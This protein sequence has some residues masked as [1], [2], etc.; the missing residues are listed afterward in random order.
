MLL[1]QMKEELVRPTVLIDLRR[2]PDSAA[3]VDTAFGGVRIGASALLADLA[4]HPVSAMVS[5]PAEAS[6]TVGTPALRNMGNARRQSL[7]AAAVLVLSS[8][9]P[10]HK[11]GGDSCP[12]AAG[13]NQ[14]H[15]IFGGGPCFIVH[16]SDP[17]VALTALDARCRGAWSLRY[18]HRS[19]RG[20]LRIAFRATR[21]RD[22]LDAGEFVTAV[23]LPGEA[24]GGVQHYE[25]LMS[26]GHGTS[27]SCHSRPRSGV[28]A[29]SVW[30]LAAWRR[31]RGA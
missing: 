27:H 8:R 3:V 10:C 23:L 5:A 6:A 16:P 22:V 1:V 12:A 31:R 30:C 17:A 21:L 26:V 14:Y 24:A 29:T 25:K 18:A 7:S 13:E 19:D 20:V 11:N 9:I 4:V 15:A 28:M 2:V